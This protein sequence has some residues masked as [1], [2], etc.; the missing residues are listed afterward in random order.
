MSDVATAGGMRTHARKRSAVHKY[1]DPG[2]PPP[3]EFDL[4]SLP[5]SAWLTT[6]EVAAVLRRAQRT[7]EMWRQQPDHPLRW[8][9][10]SGKPLYRVRDLRSFLAGRTDR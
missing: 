5:G 7:V 2:I 10:I 3:F 9:R 6:V 8:E 4:D 1:R